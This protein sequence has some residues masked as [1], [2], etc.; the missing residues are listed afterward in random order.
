MNFVT[1][2]PGVDTGT[3]HNPNL[4][5][6]ITGLPGAANLISIDGIQTQHPFNKTGDPFYSYIWPSVDAIEQVTVSIATPGADASGQGA[7]D[8]A[9]VDCTSCRGRHRND[10][11]TRTGPLA[12][13]LVFDHGFIEGPHHAEPR[14]QRGNLRPIVGNHPRAPR[15]R[16]RLCRRNTGRAAD[17]LDHL[18]A[19]RRLLRPEDGP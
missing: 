17:V 9:V 5:T 12:S 1:L 14:F 18:H 11:A 4:A 2:L 16:R 19:A 15:L 13:R 10:S 6:F 8:V 3:N 7:A